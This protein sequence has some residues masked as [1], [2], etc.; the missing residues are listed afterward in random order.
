MSNDTN[1][2]ID[3]KWPV[4]ELVLHAAPMLLLDRIV[5]A[6]ADTL[7]AEASIDKE[8]PLC[9]GET[10]LPAWWGIEYMAQSIAALAGLRE[11]VAGNDVPVGFLTGCR[12][13]NCN[14]S[15]IPLGTVFRIHI[16]ELVSLDKS[17]G[18]F[19]CRIDSEEFCAEARITV[20][21][22]GM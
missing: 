9:E 1:A 16:I 22:A 19:D 15:G 8:S 2:P 6:T 20:Y 18:A 3:C 17:L 13:F 12:K 4:D 14:K 11:R 7:E 21:G 10:E 5:E